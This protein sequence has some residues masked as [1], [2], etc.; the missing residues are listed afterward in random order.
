MTVVSDEIWDG[1][2][3]L[4]ALEPSRMD[5]ICLKCILEDAAGL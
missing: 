2:R 3:L 1:L 5:L 4:T